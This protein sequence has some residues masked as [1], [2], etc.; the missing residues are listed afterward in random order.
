MAIA[1][2]GVALPFLIASTRRAIRSR[3][4][5]ALVVLVPLT[6]LLFHAVAAQRAAAFVVVLPPL[7]LLSLA[8]WS[9][10]RWA[11]ETEA[12]PP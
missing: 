10:R 9:Y 11:W 6:V 7:G 3:V 4:I 8:G 5:G 1:L 2:T 12:A